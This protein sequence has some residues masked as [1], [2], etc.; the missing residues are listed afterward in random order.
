[1]VQVSW[2]QGFLSGLNLGVSVLNRTLT[3]T[4][5]DDKL[6]EKILKNCNRNPNLNLTTI[7]QSIFTELNQSE[8]IED[9]SISAN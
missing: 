4:I 6:W 7:S 8:S 9:S 5:S 3:N 1:M 2:T